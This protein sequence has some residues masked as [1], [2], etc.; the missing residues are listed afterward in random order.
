MML[1]R[2]GMFQLILVNEEF[3]PIKIVVSNSIKGH[4]ARLLL[5]YSPIISLDLKSLYLHFSFDKTLWIAATSW[6]GIILLR[7]SQTCELSSSK[8]TFTIAF[9]AAVNHN[10]DN[11]QRTLKHRKRIEIHQSQIINPDLLNLLK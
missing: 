11:K 7:F 8:V 5:Y 6:L 2:N 1:K 9:F 3:I 10:Y 4:G